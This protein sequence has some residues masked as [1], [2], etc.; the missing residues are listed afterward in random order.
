MSVHEALTQTDSV[1]ALTPTLPGASPLGAASKCSFYFE[2][3]CTLRA[4]NSDQNFCHQAKN[5][6]NVISF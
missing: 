1:L 2:K 3:C 6:I 4:D 5:T